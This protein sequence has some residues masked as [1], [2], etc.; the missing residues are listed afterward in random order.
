MS[1]VAKLELEIQD[2]N[3]L[4]KACNELGLELKRGQ[5]HYKWY[6]RSVGDY[7]LPEGFTEAD[8]GKCEHAIKIPNSPN[9]YEIGVV[10]NRGGRGY[11]LL[12]D[13]YAGGYGM[14]EKVGT[15]GEKL[16]QA[17]TKHLAVQHWQ[18]KGFRVTTSTNQ[19]G[20]VVVRATR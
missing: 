16:K 5:E 2:L 20:Q 10:K 7:P 15:N 18:K 17:Y 6:G 4:E 13:F 9:A 12:W 3:T 11:Q 1:H 19:K 14:Q 8:L